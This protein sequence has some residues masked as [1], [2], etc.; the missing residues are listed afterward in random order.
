MES[1]QHLQLIN[2]FKL[3]ALSS[4]SSCEIYTYLFAELS[5]DI[6]TVMVDGIEKPIELEREYLFS[7]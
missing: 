4:L 6:V 7:N 1:G 3:S 5:K 2:D